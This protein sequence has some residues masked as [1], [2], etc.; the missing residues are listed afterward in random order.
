MESRGETRSSLLDGDGGA[1]SV[2]YLR[3]PWGC[4]LQSLVSTSGSVGG[5]LESPFAAKVEVRKV[6]VLAARCRGDMGARGLEL[7]HRTVV[8]S[9]TGGRKGCSQSGS[10]I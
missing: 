9:V 7:A 8:I 1:I 10:N 5:G 3:P 4:R 6:L 2:T